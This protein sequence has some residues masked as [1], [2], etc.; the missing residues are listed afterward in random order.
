M[1][2]Y[3]AKKI[4]DQ[5]LRYVSEGVP[6]EDI[7]S[8]TKVK[9]N[10]ELADLL[11]TPKRLFKKEEVLE[12]TNQGALK[13]FSSQYGG[14]KNYF[15]DTLSKSVKHQFESY[16]YSNVFQDDLEE[17]IILEFDISNLENRVDNTIIDILYWSYFFDKNLK[18]D[19]NELKK[20]E[21]ILDINLQFFNNLFQAELRNHYKQDLKDIKTNAPF[22]KVYEKLLSKSLEKKQGAAFRQKVRAIITDTYHTCSKKNKQAEESEDTQTFRLEELRSIHK[23]FKSLTISDKNTSSDTD[24][25][26]SD[27]SSPNDSDEE[28]YNDFKKGFVP[29]TSEA[30]KKEK[31]ELSLIAKGN[32]EKSADDKAPKSVKGASTSLPLS[33]QSSGQHYPS[34]SPLNTSSSLKSAKKSSSTKGGGV[35]PKF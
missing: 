3:C 23:A 17:T 21:K 13:G 35:R 18:N 27:G 4:T 2:N 11:T 31:A 34:D 29:G 33:H 8:F 9:T 20:H 1:R 6:K 28:M 5:F 25:S 30:S 7:Y 15:L 24:S 12:F 14:H 10:T 22:M 19:F 16:G 26:Y 32:P